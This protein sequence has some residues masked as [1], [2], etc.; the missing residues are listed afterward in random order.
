MFTLLN[1]FGIF[2]DVMKLIARTSKFEE[3]LQVFLCV[4]H[5]SNPPLALQVYIVKAG[6]DLGKKEMLE[7]T[8]EDKSS[9]EIPKETITKTNRKTGSKKA[10][11]PV[12]VSGRKG[13]S[14]GLS[15]ENDTLDISEESKGLKE[16]KTEEKKKPTRVSSRKRSSRL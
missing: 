3:D 12:R 14:N 9:K 15:L 16:T 6:D 1:V 7:D 10:G 2:H 11:N 4:M 8:K 5:Q 13:R